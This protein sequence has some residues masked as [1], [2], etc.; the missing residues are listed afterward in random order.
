MRRL[1]AEDPERYRMAVWRDSIT[2]RNYGVTFD[3]LMEQIELQG[4]KCPICSTPYIMDKRSNQG[5]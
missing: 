5:P 1:R 4:M 3:W 2:R